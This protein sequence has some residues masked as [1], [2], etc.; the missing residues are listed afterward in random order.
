MIKKESFKIRKKTY[1]NQLR[2]I[3]WSTIGGSNFLKIF[4]VGMCTTFFESIQFI[5][6][7]F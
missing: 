3:R 4:L 5:L 1:Q 2:L 6:R 7:K